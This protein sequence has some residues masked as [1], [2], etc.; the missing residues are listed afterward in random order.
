[1]PP[2]TYT[3]MHKTALHLK[4]PSKHPELLSVLSSDPKP[5][6]IILKIDLED[7][8]MGDLI[9]YSECEIPAACQ[10]FCKSYNLPI[11]SFHQTLTT[12]VRE[13]LHDAT[14]PLAAFPQKDQNL[15]YGQK[16][17]PTNR[18][19]SKKIP[20][21]KIE[22]VNQT[23]DRL[24]LNATEGAA[25]REFMNDRKFESMHPF[26]PDLT[27][28]NPRRSESKSGSK[29]RINSS[30]VGPRSVV[31]RHSHT[32]TKSNMSLAVGPHLTKSCYNPL[33]DDAKLNKL[34]YPYYGKLQKSA[35]RPGHYL[36]HQNL[37]G[38][39]RHSRVESCVLAESKAANPNTRLNSG[40][41]KQLI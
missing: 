17:V 22:Q 15:E 6:L 28:L 36:S 34:A 35:N 11:E 16:L 3:A 14:K 25:Y 20:K 8:R 27:K 10:R 33:L 37:S 23:F 41:K 24:W 2:K 39:N 40:T 31:G 21:E 4:T 1:M 26:K 5:P 19:S 38:A 7:G 32:H 13:Q 30:V 29:S 18:N 9:I 12:F